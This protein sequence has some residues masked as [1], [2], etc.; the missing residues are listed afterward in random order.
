[1]SMTASIPKGG[2][3]V[4]VLETVVVAVCMEYHISCDDLFGSIVYEAEHLSQLF[5]RLRKVFLMQKAYAFIGRIF[6]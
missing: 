3:I 6:H 4:V 5:R 2:K 1:M